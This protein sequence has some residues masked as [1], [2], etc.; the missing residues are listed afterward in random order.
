MSELLG[1]TSHAARCYHLCCIFSTVLLPLLWSLYFSTYHVQ[2]SLLLA[3]WVLFLSLGS[4]TIDFNEFLAIITEKIGEPDS[5]EE[6][7]RA[8]DSMKAPG[9]EHITLDSLMR[10]AK[11]LGEDLMSTFIH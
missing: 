4:G 8:W 5:I 9:A 10:V 3:F 2:S 11:D 1:N 6:V 7:N